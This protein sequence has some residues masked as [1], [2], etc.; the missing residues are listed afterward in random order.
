MSNEQTKPAAPAAT[1]DYK[2]VVTVAAMLIIIIATL[3]ML[4]RREVSRRMDAEKALAGLRE[5]QKQSEMKDNLMRMLMQGQQSAPQP[6]H[7]EEL[8][9]ETLNVGQVSRTVLHLGAA[10]ARRMGF[11][12]GD[13]I[14]VSEAPRATMPGSQP[15]SA[16]R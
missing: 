12:P 8:P 3:A 16:T 4:W 5:Q 13:V 6:I 7:R 2:F 15:T 14:I 9:Q 11:M 10:A 1:L